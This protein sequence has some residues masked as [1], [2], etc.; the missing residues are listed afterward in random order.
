[1]AGVIQ[2]APRDAVPVAEQPKA[3]PPHVGVAHESG[4]GSLKHGADAHQATARA[5]QSAI[6]NLEPGK[7]I[8]VDTAGTVHHEKDPFVDGRAS[9]LVS[10]RRMD[11]SGRVVVFNGL[12]PKNELLI[13]PG[14]QR[15]FGEIPDVPPHASHLERLK[16][17]AVVRSG[18]EIWLGRD[19]GFAVPDRRVGHEAGFAGAL[20]K[21]LADGA[22]GQFLVLGRQ[23]VKECPETVSRAHCLIEVL[24]KDPLPDDTFSMSVRVYPGI[25]SELPVMVQHDFGVTEQVLGQRTVSSGSAIRLSGIGSVEIPHLKGSL[26][27]RSQSLAESFS[28]R[29]A[30]RAEEALKTYVAPERLEYSNQ[31]IDKLRQDVP[32][33]ELLLKTNVLQQHICNGLRMIREGKHQEAIGHFQE[34]DVLQL[35]GYRFEWSHVW[36]LRALTHEAVLENLHGIAGDSW[37][38][39]DRRLVNP[40]VGILAPG[41]APQNDA[42]QKLLDRWQHDISLL[43]AEEYCHALQHGLGHKLIARKAALIPLLDGFKELLKHEADIAMFFHEQGVQLSSDLVTNRYPIRAEVMELIGGFQPP[44]TQELFRGALRGVSIGEVLAVGRNPSEFARSGAGAHGFEI[45]HPE[46]NKPTGTE[47][48]LRPID[49]HDKLLP[50]EAIIGRNGD[51]SFLV[52]PLSG[53]VVFAPDSAGYYRRIGQPVSLEPGVPIYIGR[54]FRLV[55][56]DG[57]AGS[58]P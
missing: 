54:A 37:C 6:L 5:I 47:L 53:S 14:S 19:C 2:H 21:L 31:V 44:G 17:A 22:V 45:P 27:E 34:E 33:E 8:Y 11:N 49:Q 38:R 30:R 41:L 36:T 12:P 25:P 20:S 24:S 58:L 39:H 43:F 42:E 4:L 48:A 46:Q 26:E 13:R 56:E 57:M 1:M 23:A 50:V 3:H 28:V 15:S 18:E 29:K 9:P 51:G 52:T 32:N 10:F 55:L 16:Y 7:E 40:A 35:F